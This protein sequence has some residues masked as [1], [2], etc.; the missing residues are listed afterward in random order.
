MPTWGPDQQ[1]LFAYTGVV[2]EYLIINAKS[3]TY[4][5]ASGGT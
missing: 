1:F 5:T 2:D 3:G 4:L